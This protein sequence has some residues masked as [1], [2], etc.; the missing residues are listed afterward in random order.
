MAREIPGTFVYED[1]FCAAF[2]SI[3]PIA[4]GHLLVVPR[5]EIDQWV[6]LDGASSGAL[7]AV[8]RRIAEALRRSF[9]CE[10]IA[11]IVAGFEVPHCHLHLIPAASMA[12]LDFSRAATD[13][14]R[15]DLEEAAARIRAE[16]V[17]G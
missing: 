5:T 10:R 14:A 7:F 16:L 3:N 6:D 15:T 12:D 2:M 1:E 13:I 4:T 8:A 17:A 9:Q 11:L